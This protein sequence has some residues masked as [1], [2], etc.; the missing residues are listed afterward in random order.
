M[1]KSILQLEELSFKSAVTR[2]RKKRND[3]EING[4]VTET[5]IDIINQIKN[6]G[7]KSLFSFTKKFDGVDLDAASI[8]VSKEALD[9]AHRNISSELKEAIDTAKK[10]I[11]DYHLHQ[12]ME[13]WYYTDNQSLLGQKIGPIPSVGLYAPGGK[14]AYPSTVLMNAVPAVIAGVPRIIMCTPPDKTGNLSD[15]VLYAASISGI[16][17]IYKI[18]GAQAIAAMA[19]G[20]DSVSAVDKIC[21]PG[22]KYVAEAKR[23]LYGYVDIDMIAGPSEVLIYA[24]DSA[25]PDYI[26]ADLFAQAEHDEDAK[27]VF[28]TESKTLLKRVIIRMNER[29]NDQK[30]Y[31]IIKKAVNQNGLAVIVNSEKEAYEI[32]NLYAPEHLEVITTQSRDNVIQSVKNA[33]AVFIGEFTPEAIG[34]YLAGPN[35][36]LPTA[37]TARFSS[38]LGVYDFMKRSSIISFS[39]TDL[40]RFSKTSVKFAESEGLDAHAQSISLRIKDA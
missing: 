20:T 5:V 34:D 24:D 14:A 6:N 15:A 23:L 12:K 28:V 35:H 2:F 3:F 16:D 40:Q 1:D 19:L 7:D 25:D 9:N 10:R 33:G 39:R 36:T 11:Y 13:S 38:P 32:I 18:G 4:P 17:E 31:D 22:N 8:M 21:G 29:L 30:R 37:G 26:A 27:V